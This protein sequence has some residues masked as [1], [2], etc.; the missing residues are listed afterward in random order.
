MTPNAAARFDAGREAAAR[1]AHA[2]V[3]ARAREEAHAHPPGREN[4]YGH[5]KRLE[6]I[7]ARLRERRESLGSARPLRVL[8]IGCGTGVMITR[9]LASLGHEVTGLDL[10]PVSIRQASRLNVAPTLP[11]LTYVAGRLEEQRWDGAF[12]AVV[13]SEVLEHLPDPD[14]LVD[15]L[16]RCLRADGL[17]L[18]TV[19]NGYGPFE[20]DSY[21]WEALHRIPGF[22][23][24][25]SAWIK[26]KARVLDLAGRG[27][28]ARAATEVEDRP[29]S[30][31]TLNE[32]SPHCQRFTRGKVVRLMERHGLRL[33]GWGK[34][35]VWS[36]PI[37]HTLLRDWGAAIRLNCALADRLPAWMT[38][39]LYFCFARVPTGPGAPPD[40]R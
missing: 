26:S 10:D 4:V 30:R 15:A 11:N 20:I 17:L 37:A 27:A 25:E 40:A 13:A 12:D 36:G 7:A 35:A 31:A 2:S 3:P 21:V 9:P 5:R 28:A 34:S 32:N 39:G 38:S 24:L 1:D 29:D 33:A 8:D 18:L 22:W 6:F 19:P 23:R 14:A 16:A